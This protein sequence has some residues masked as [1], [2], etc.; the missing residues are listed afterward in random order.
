MDY[1]GLDACVYCDCYEQGTV[2]T[3][4]PQPELVYVD[5]CGQVSLREDAPGANVEAF[6]A[7][8][9]TACLHGHRTHLLHHH[10]GNIALIGFL[11]GLLIRTPQKFPI[12][13]AKV[14]YN[15]SHSG[16]HLA[17]STVELLQ[18][19]MEALKSLHCDS[20]GNE[21]RVRIF[22]RQLTELIQA[23]LALRKPIAF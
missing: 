3:P 10:L 17:P 18:P 4:P 21:E 20:P 13:L 11:H 7:W 15:G 14:V 12:L 22:E 1:M 8:V 6:D 2:H 23:S 16:D 5:Q 9:R 19:E